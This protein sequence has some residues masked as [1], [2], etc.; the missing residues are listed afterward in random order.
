MSV[1]QSIRGR[2]LLV[3]LLLACLI[4]TAGVNWLRKAGGNQEPHRWYYDMETRELVVVS[5]Q[6]PDSPITL[7]SGHQA[8]AAVVFGCGR[9]DDAA[10]RLFYLSRMEVAEPASAPSLPS[11]YS[12]GRP[13]VY[14]RGRHDDQWHEAASPQGQRVVDL[15]SQC[16][17]AE[18]LMCDP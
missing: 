12:G 15:R 17:E 3:V 13:V 5:R 4:L 8:Y 1:F 18:L 7:P 6:H 2:P 11:G 10:K 14:V 16:R 9:C